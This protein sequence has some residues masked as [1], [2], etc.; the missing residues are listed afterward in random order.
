MGG[1]ATTGAPPE[2]RAEDTRRAEVILM[3]A[4]WRV[5]KRIA[6]AGP[7]RRASPAGER[8]DTE[9]LEVSRPARDRNGP[10]ARRRGR[11]SCLKTARRQYPVRMCAS[12]VE[13]TSHKWRPPPSPAPPP[14]NPPP[15]PPPP[16]R[17]R[18]PLPSNCG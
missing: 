15:I 13:G 7:I 4:D 2:I 1:I 12:R 6:A 11:E 17:A 16:P 10:W 9:R 5:L 18:P 8:F 3:L 14:I